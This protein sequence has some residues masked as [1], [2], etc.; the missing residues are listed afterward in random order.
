MT[1]PERALRSLVRT[2]AP[3]LPGLTCWNSMTVKRPS[4]ILMVM[5]FLMSLVEIAAISPDTFRARCVAHSRQRP[6]VPDLAGREEALH[7]LDR[8]FVARSP[9]TGDRAIH[10]ARQGAHVAKG[11]AGRGIRQVDLNLDPVKR[12]Q[13][14]GQRPRRVREGPGVEHDRHGRAVGPVHCL[15]EVAFKIRLE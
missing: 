2:K 4:S 3:P 10:H 12:A 7:R 5:P 15:Y 6:K 9:E 11:L 13:R 1:A 8:Q 14:V